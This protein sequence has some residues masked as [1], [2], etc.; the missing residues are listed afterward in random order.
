M[1]N[2]LSLCKSSEI[3]CNAKIVNKDRASYTFFLCDD[4]EFANA[5]QIQL[6][7]LNVKQIQMV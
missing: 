7:I 4:D 2:I 3:Q 5:K 1:L 6:I